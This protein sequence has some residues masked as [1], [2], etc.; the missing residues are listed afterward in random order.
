MDYMNHIVEQICVIGLGYIGLPT[1]AI[2]SSNRFNVC[3]VDINEFAVD[4]INQGKIHIVE[5]ELDILVK[6]AVAKGHLKANLKPV[7]ADVFIIT[8][9]TP[10]DKNNLPDLSYVKQAVDDIASF[11]QKGNL[12]ILESTSPVGTTEM[13]SRRLADLR[14]DLNFP[15]NN[16]ALDPDVN[17]AY[18]PERVLPGKIIHELVHNDRIIGGITPSCS[19]KVYE[20][21]SQFVEGNLKLVNARTA[22]LCKLTENSYRDVNI[23]FANE[24]SMICDKLDI[25]VDEVIEKS[26][27]HP[28]V[29]I[30]NP[31]PGVGGH[32]LAVDPW[33][34]VASAES[35]AK[36]IKTA[37]EVNLKKTDWVVDKVLKT[38]ANLSSKTPV[39]IACLGLSYK[40]DIDDLR[41]SPALDIAKKISEVHSG[42][43]LTVEPNVSDLPKKLMDS[44]LSLQNLESAIKEADIIVKLVNHKE[45]TDLENNTLLDGKILLSF[46]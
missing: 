8:V 13:I 26:N 17:I 11:I 10:I 40:A 41:E 24:L 32:C 5:P 23:A 19:Q 42:P 1:S 38:V 12:V 34:I 6:S 18:C 43:V 2:L 7:K 30:L 22:E 21:Y 25:D 35:E 44:A 29:N 4:T 39:T 31:G 16:L 14:P 3:G 27:L 46:C 33:F 28:R 37:R 45:F 20:L 36:L 15:T 9:P